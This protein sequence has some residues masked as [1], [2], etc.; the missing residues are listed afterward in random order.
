MICIYIYFL[1]VLITGFW[2]KFAE[3]QVNIDWED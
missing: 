1:V 3:K 2:F